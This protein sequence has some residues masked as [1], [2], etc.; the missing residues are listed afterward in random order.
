MKELIQSNK[1][2]VLKNKNLNY[3]T[4]EHTDKL[5]FQTDFTCNLAFDKKKGREKLLVKV[6][7]PSTIKKQ[8]EIIKK[9]FQKNRKQ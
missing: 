5:L 8:E 1:L 2:F 7:Y 4:K 6:P 3:W 9:M